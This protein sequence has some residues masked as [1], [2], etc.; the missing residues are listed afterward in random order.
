[1]SKLRAEAARHFGCD[2]TTAAIAVYGLNLGIQNKTL[3]DRTVPLIEDDCNQPDSPARAI[4]KSS[5]VPCHA[6][7]NTT[8]RALP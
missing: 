5:A 1:M 8:N 6:K 4:A 7:Y 3:Y 2:P